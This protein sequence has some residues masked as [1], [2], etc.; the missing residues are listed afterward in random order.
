[1]KLRVK[2]SEKPKLRT[3]QG[4]SDV[5][6]ILISS[7]DGGKSDTIYNPVYGQLTGGES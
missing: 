6:C 4:G 1:M 2:T 3:R 5:G 7:I